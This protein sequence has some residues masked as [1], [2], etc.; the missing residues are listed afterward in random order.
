MQGQHRLTHLIELKYR[1]KEQKDIMRYD[2]KFDLKN[3]SAQ[4][5]GR[6]HFIK[7]IERLEDKTGDEKIA[8]GK[9]YCIMLT[10]DSAYYDAE[11]Y[12]KR[13]KKDTR[14]R[15]FRIHQGAKIKQ[16]NPDEKLVW[17]LKS[18]D[19]RRSYMGDPLE[20]KHEYICKWEPYCTVDGGDKKSEFK[21]LLLEI[22]PEKVDGHNHKEVN[23]G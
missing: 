3:Q 17:N 14:D 6:Y 21:Y 13:K 7:D 11:R 22:P 4:D 2:R 15:N 12:D 8:T 9:S 1:T 19:E 10:N 5:L 18:K 23:H 16:I 20:I